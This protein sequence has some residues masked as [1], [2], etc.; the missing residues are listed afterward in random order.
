MIVTP[1]F[2]S[3]ETSWAN[4]LAMSDV[5]ACLR[6]GWKVELSGL[7][8]TWEGQGGHQRVSHCIR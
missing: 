6:L 2:L 4:I 7:E 5:R 3:S 1:S 8:A